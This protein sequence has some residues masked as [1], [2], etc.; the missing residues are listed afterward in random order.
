MRIST[1]FPSEYLKAADLQGHN[2]R[3]VIDRV[4]MRDIGGDEKPVLFFQGKEKGV[5]LN[6][7]NSTN[8]AIAYGDETDEWTGKEVILFEAMVDFQGRS[9]AAIRIRPPA[10]KDRPKPALKVASTP[11]QAQPS[12]NPAAPFDDNI[13]F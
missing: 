12:E 13:P 11:A 9:V 2:I 5:V 7:T 4:E 6:K 10:A 8:I 3:V 1:A